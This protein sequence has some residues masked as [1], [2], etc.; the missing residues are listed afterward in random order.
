MLLSVMNSTKDGLVDKRRQLA[1]EHCRFQAR[2]YGVDVCVYYV[3]QSRPH[4]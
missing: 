2:N 4:L 1:R 3:F